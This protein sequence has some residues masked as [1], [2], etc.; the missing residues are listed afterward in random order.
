MLDNITE[1]SHPPDILAMK[2]IAT[3][4]VAIMGARIA[5]WA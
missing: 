1:S 2:H 3:A 4:A 5:W